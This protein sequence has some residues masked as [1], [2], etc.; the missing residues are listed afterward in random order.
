MREGDYPPPSNEK[1]WTPLEI[2]PND[3]RYKG[4]CEKYE[5]DI[6]KNLLKCNLTTMK[7]N[8]VIL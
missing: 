8:K 1:A 6:V 7:V 2:G 4:K 5:I 3:Q